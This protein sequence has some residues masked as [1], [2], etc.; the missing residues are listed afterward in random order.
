MRKIEFRRHALKYSDKDT[1]TPE[2]IKQARG[3]GAEELRG[4]GYTHSVTGGQ[5]HNVQTM[6]YMAEGAGDF[7]STLFLFSPALY[8]ER[9]KEVIAYVKKHGA[10][11]KPDHPLIKQESL[12]MAE[13]FAGLV[14][15]LPEN[16]RMLVIGDS[17]IIEILV[18]GLTN[19]VI[20]PIGEHDKLELDDTQFK[21]GLIF[22]GDL[23]V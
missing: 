17:I 12:R 15:K 11:V 8:T 5:F 22:D 23:P 3:I 4:K 9:E 16:S 14:T 7:S 10:V 20:N 2:G 1:L 19:K 21:R 13:E 6:T 18:F